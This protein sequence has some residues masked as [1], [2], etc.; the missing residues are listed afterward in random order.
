MSKKQSRRD[1][2]KLLGAGAAVASSPMEL[3]LDKL[4]PSLIERAVAKDTKALANKYILIQQFAAPPRWMYDLFLSPY[5]SNPMANIMANGSV[6]SELTGGSRYTGV[7]YKT[8]KVKGINAPIVWKYDVADGTGAAR[9]I[10]DLMDNMIV[11]QGIDALN[12]GHS[13]AAALVNR[14]LTQYSIDGILA[15][16]AGLPFGGIGLGSTA[17]DFKS[18]KGKNAKVYSGGQDMATLLPEAFAAGVGDLH[19][20]YSKEIDGAVEKLNRGIA[21]AKLGSSSLSLDQNG[22]RKLME[23][24]VEK[25]AAAY[26][27]LLAK[28]ETIISETIKMSQGLKGLTDKPVGKTGDR[29]GDLDY[30]ES[31][32]DHIIND[33]DMRDTI[34]TANVPNLAKEFAVAEYVITNNLTSS[35]AVGMP[36]MRVRFNGAT[37]SVTKDQ[38]RT[39]VFNSVFYTA[40]FYRISSACILGL[41]DGL[42]ATPYKGS[43]M[44]D[45]SVIRQSGEFGR[46]PRT[47]GSGSDHS[48]WSSNCMLLSGMIKGPIIAGQILKDGASIGRR[49][50]SWGAAGRLKHGPTAT[51][52][53]VISSI[54]TMLGI[55]TPSVNNPSLL[56]KNEKGEVELNIGYI[57]KTEVV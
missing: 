56:I 20:E 3:F 47:D 50:G 42:K 15:D 8:H 51:T 36:N 24:E 31:A 13:P 6:A 18:P 17:L 1:V 19:K 55:Q 44:F 21:S 22:A 54:A 27:A 10:S 7:T 23:G 29:T 30:R 12:P 9:P 39:G 48:P 53:H 25:I 46:H 37:R 43:N 52:G 57:D 40:L 34:K 26:P 33:T 16:K 49:P 14:P 11:L 5:G 41:I 35:V 32:G 2:L 28:Y 38:H 4:V 45:H